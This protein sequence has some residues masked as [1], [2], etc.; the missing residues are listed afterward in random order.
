VTE[1]TAGAVTERYTYDDSG[2]R[3]RTTRAGTPTDFLYAGPDIHAE[4]GSGWGAPQ[5]LTV[6]GPGS[7]DALLRLSGVGLATPRY[8]H[9]DGLGS[10]VAASGAANTRNNLAAAS[11]G[12]AVTQIAGGLY[13]GFSVAATINAERAGVNPT[14]GGLWLGT[15]GSVLELALPSSQSIEGITLYFGQDNYLDPAE[16][17]EAMDVSTNLD[18]SSVSLQYWTGAAWQPV[19]GGS[20]TGNAKVIAHLGFA[21]IATDRLRLTLVDDASNGIAPNDNVVALAEVE[22]YALPSGGATAT[23]R[24]DAWGNRIGASGSVPVYGYPGREPTDAAIG[25]SYHRARFCDPSVGRFISKDPLGLANGEISPYLYAASN[26]ILFTDPYGLLPQ[27]AAGPGSYWGSFTDTLSDVGSSLYNALPT[28]A[29]MTTALDRTQTALDI[30][31][32]AAQGPLEVAG[33]WIDLTNAGISAQRGDWAGA[34]LSAGAA[35]PF[36][37]AVANVAKVG[38]RAADVVAPAA[39]QLPTQLELPFVPS[40]P[41]TRGFLTLDPGVQMPLASGWKGGPGGAMLSG[42][43]GFDIVTRTHVEGHAAAAMRQHGAS[44]GTLYIN[45]PEICASCAKLLPD[46]LP[47]N[48]HLTVILPNGTQVPFV[49]NTR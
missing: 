4:Y 6:H 34:S 21:P 48:A 49:G 13:S 19:P 47:T 44:T 16:P 42:A 25:L 35:V 45:N 33:P 7:D 2:R 38:G 36:I 9:A 12:G 32:L 8:F 18:T 22:V 14:A 20:I 28:R 27:I 31:G 30:A 39:H 17:L 46:M 1:L 41:L 43:P 24:F 23:Q 3:I 5:A 15:S 37:G 26:P 29:Q 40:E 11:A 10:V